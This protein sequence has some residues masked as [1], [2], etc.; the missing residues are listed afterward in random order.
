MVELNEKDFATLAIFALRYSMG[1]RSYAPGYV[2]GIV[3]P[4]IKE[5]SHG[6]LV[7]MANDCDDQR[8]MEQYGDPI[9]DRPGWLEWEQL[10]KKE[11][12]RRENE[13]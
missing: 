10:V 3:K 8:R 1:R 12:A 5:I 11:K 13:L 6:D 9:I 2:T 7:V 4:H